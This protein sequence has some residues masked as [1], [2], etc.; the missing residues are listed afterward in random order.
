MG[1]WLENYL[2]PKRYHLKQNGQFMEGIFSKIN[3]HPPEN[4]NQA[5]HFFKFPGLTNTF[6]HPTPQEIP[7]CSQQEVGTFAGT[8]Q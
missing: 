5:S 8:A 4:S 2:I 3:P 1:V 7:I 6:H